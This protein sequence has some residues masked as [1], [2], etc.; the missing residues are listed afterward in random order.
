M[1]DLFQRLGEVLLSSRLSTLDVSSA[2]TSYARA[3][4]IQDMGIIDHLMDEMVENMNQFSTRQ[5]VEGIWACAKLY[6]YEKSMLDHSDGGPPPYWRNVLSLATE[7]VNRKDALTSK[8]TAQVLYS[9]GLLELTDDEV[10]S[11]LSKRASEQWEQFTGQELANILWGMSKVKS[12]S[13]DSI[14][15]LLRRIE[16]DDSLC[17]TPQEASNI[18]YAL[19]H[20]DIRH[21]AVFTKLCNLVLDQIDSASAQTVANVLWASRAV[22]FRPPQRLLEPRPN[23]SGTF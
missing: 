20:L 11:P 8:D 3:A 5:I 18:L 15:V 19:G 16:T 22:F 12:K 4:Y 13:F 14:F 21:E 7:V 23:K 17:L 1:F 9:L 2:L 6:S 10:V